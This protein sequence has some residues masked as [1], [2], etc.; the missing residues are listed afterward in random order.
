M[1]PSRESEP[2]IPLLN[3]LVRDHELEWLLCLSSTFES[4]RLQGP[5]ASKASK[6]PLQSE[7]AGTAAG[8]AARLSVWKFALRKIQKWRRPET[9]RVD[10]A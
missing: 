7:R 5:I 2:K 3:L 6:R 1:L 8:I 9:D 4:C 10:A